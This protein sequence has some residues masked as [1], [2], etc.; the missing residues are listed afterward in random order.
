MAVV[1]LPLRASVLAAAVIACE[2]GSVAA[3]PQPLVVAIAGPTQIGFGDSA[4]FSAAIIGD[5]ELVATPAIIWSTPD[6]FVARMSA[7]GELVT[8]GYGTARVIATYETS[9]DTHLVSVPLTPFAPTMAFTSMSFTGHPLHYCGL[10]VSGQVFCRGDNEYGQLGNGSLTG[11]DE[12]TPVDTDARFTHLEVGQFGG[13]ALDAD[14]QM[15]CWGFNNWHE[16]SPIDTALRRIQSPRALG[17]DLRFIELAH[18]EHGQTCGI[19]PEHEPYCWGHNDFYQ[20]GRS[21]SRSRLSGIGRVSGGITLREIDG[22]GFSMCGTTAAGDLYCWGANGGTAFLRTEPA[23]VHI[24]YPE[25]LH[26]VSVGVDLLCALTN[27]GAAVCMGYNTYGGLGNGTVGGIQASPTRVSSDQQFSQ[28]AV[29]NGVCALTTDGALYCW[30]AYVGFREFDISRPV[31][32]APDLRF[33]N[34]HG[35]WPSDRICAIT[36]DLVTYCFDERYR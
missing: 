36:M 17:T 15:H 34:I 14:G 28:L 27:S 5:H 31:R 32:V 11:G 23:P 9:S 35:D 25:P 12:W 13:C 33:R 10:T 24:A 18:T 19:S 22:D 7:T 21:P 4:T 1:R 6:T 8:R 3:P 30:G 20:T 2:N 26:G 29:A 16:H